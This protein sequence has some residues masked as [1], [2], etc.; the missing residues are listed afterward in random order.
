MRLLRL[1]KHRK[2]IY[3]ILKIALKPKVTPMEKTLWQ[4]DVE[5]VA[6]KIVKKATS[7]ENNNE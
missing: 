6:R 3:Y 1:F 5:T 2:E 4:E 7:R